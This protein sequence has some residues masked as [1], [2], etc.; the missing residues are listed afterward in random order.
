MIIW[1][2][3]GSTNQILA[4]MTLLVISVMLIRLGRP[5]RYTL[6]PMAFVLFTSF[7]AGVIKLVEYWKADNYLLVTIDMVVLVTSI[8][9]IL[10]SMSVIFR[11]KR[12]SSNAENAEKNP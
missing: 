9:V 4:A 8:L 1:P 3:F 10:E 6:I 2:L 7:Y 11:L 5:A 12:E